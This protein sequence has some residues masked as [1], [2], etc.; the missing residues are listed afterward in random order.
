VVK[1]GRDLD[2]GAKVEIA[3]GAWRFGIACGPPGPSPSTSLKRRQR[4]AAAV[5]EAIA[6]LKDVPPVALKGLDLDAVAAFD[7]A[8]RAMQ[9]EFSLA[10][11]QTGAKTTKRIGKPTARYVARSAA[12]SFARLTGRPPTVITPALGGKAGGPFLEF[13]HQVFEVLGIRASA[14]SQARAAIAMDFKGEKLPP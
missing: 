3:L 5:V 14:E 2:E 4:L 1:A 11:N 9:V 6:A 8:A 7:V 12:D 13:L 10:A